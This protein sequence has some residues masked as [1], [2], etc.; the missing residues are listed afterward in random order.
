VVKFDEPLAVQA[1]H[2][3][4]CV[5]TGMQ[6]RTDGANG[7]A[8]VQVIEAAQLSLERDRRVLLEEV[9]SGAPGAGASV[10]PLPLGPRRLTDDR[11]AAS[12]S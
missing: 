8:V 10:I 2:F 3:V 1:N 4:E 9:T 5:T 6:P 7:L 12:R 11:H